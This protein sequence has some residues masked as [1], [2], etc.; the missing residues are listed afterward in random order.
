V[1]ARMTVSSK[2]NSDWDH[3]Q[4]LYGIGRERAEAFLQ[5]HFDDLNVRSSTD[6]QAKFL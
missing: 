5:N 3:L 1:M 6:I 2:I 4:R